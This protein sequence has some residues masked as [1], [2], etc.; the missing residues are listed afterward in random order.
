[1]VRTFKVLAAAAVVYAVVLG[2]GGSSLLEVRPM[3]Q[4]IPANSTIYFLAESRVP[5]DVDAVMVDL[6][7]DVMTRIKETAAFGAVFLGRCTDSCENALNVSGTITDVRKVS[8]GKRFLIGSWAGEARL[9]V[10]LV[11]CD[12]SSGDTLGFYVIEGKSGDTDY[13]GGTESAI[14]RTA[15]EI[16]ELLVSHV[17]QW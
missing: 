16:A 8:P 3:E 11:I 10:D 13:S 4:L 15:K 14:G 12:A 17:A 6:E 2:C 5:D 1:M 9:S 7:T